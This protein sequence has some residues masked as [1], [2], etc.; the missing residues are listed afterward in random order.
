MNTG[1]RAATA[2]SSRQVKQQLVRMLFGPIHNRTGPEGH[3][4]LDSSSYSFS[5]LK[6]A[7]LSRLHE[8]HPDKN[9]SNMSSADAD[10]L[11]KTFH[12][13]Q[14][15]W[16]KY[17]ELAKSMNAV[18]NGSEDMA[19]FTKFGVGC[20]FSDND[21]ERALRDEITEQACRGWFASGLLTESTNK[22]GNG[23][24]LPRHHVSLLDESLFEEISE[25]EKAIAAT[26]EPK[27]KSKRQAKHLIPGL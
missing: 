22:T 17:E 1:T 20:S 9:K 11:K 13:L 4:K 24:S 10:S 14:E 2:A 8:I 26:T 21:E 12:E 25:D 3:M 23:T 27:D 18:Q 15:A 19:T 6:K 7:Y 16:S 5:D